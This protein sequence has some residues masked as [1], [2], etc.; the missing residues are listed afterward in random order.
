MNEIKYR[1]TH[2]RI[3]I[4]FALKEEAAPFQKVAAAQAAS[5]L[6][7]GIGRQNAEKSVR[8]FLAGW[9]A[10]ASG[11]QFPASRRKPSGATPERAGGTPA[12]PWS[13]TKSGRKGWRG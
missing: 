8:E 10:H 1:A 4:S 12:L 13:F 2:S 5:I 7:T 3:I 6:L 9:G 11:V